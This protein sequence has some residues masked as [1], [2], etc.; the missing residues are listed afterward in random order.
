MSDNVNEIEVITEMEKAKEIFEK[1]KIKNP[2]MLG[3]VNMSRFIKDWNEIVIALQKNLNYPIKHQRIFPYLIEDIKNL[4][5]EEF[6]N[7]Q[8]VELP[9]G[10]LLNILLFKSSFDSGFENLKEQI[11]E[12]RKNDKP[13]IIYIDDLIDELHYSEKFSSLL[14]YTFRFAF[15]KEKEKS[16]FLKKSDVKF[17]TDD[18]NVYMTIGGKV[19]SKMSLSFQEENELFNL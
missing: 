12:K 16:P 2:S 18:D 19:V 9:C 5:T 6:E 11:K 3:K 10:F 1:R 4:P 13:E 14:K 8:C 17:F 15:N 7:N